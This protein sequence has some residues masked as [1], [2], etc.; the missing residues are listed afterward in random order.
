[1]AP[2][3]AI[4]RVRR[5]CNCSSYASPFSIAFWKIVGLLVTPTTFFLSRSS[6]RL[7]VR[8][9]SRLMSSSQI[10]TPSS[11]SCASASLM[12]CPL[13]VACCGAPDATSPLQG[14]VRSGHD[15]V[16]GE[17]E[18]LEEHV[19]FG[20]GAEMVDCDDLAA[21][22][23]DLA[24]TLRDAGLDAHPRLDVGRQD[25]LL[26]GRRLGVEPLDAGHRDDPHG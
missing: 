1:M 23:D 24:P 4:C 7:P 2:S 26:V 6:C 25:L 17:A 13:S 19:A 11:D 3:T 15:A 9:R 21:V 8:S 12:S 10:E 5:S 18:L 22:A 16:R 14:G 20:A